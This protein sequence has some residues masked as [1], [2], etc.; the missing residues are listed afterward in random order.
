MHVF[1]GMIFCIAAILFQL[2]TTANHN[3]ILNYYISELDTMR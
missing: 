1:K 3:A 2:Q